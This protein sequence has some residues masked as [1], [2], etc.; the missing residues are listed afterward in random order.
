MGKV[1]STEQKLRT[2]PQDTKRKDST[3]KKIAKEIALYKEDIIS[4]KQQKLPVGKPNEFNKKYL[5]QAELIENR[6]LVRNIELKGIDNV[7]QLR[8]RKNC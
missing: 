1:S 8:E 7:Q 5:L 4:K 3:S 6:T 2:V